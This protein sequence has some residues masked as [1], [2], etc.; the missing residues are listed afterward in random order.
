MQLARVPVH[1]PLTQAS[2]S[3]P[4]FS[5]ISTNLQFRSSALGQAQTWVLT[6]P[7]RHP[8]FQLPEEPGCLQGTAPIVGAS[9]RGRNA[10]KQ[11]RT[12]KA[13]L[14]KT[15]PPPVAQVRI[16]TMMERCFLDG[17]VFPN[18]SISC[19]RGSKKNK[20]NKIKELNCRFP[21]KRAE[22]PEDP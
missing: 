3:A 8:W 17:K 9:P 15:F 11:W 13:E 21:E 1:Q 7:P 5:K 22:T 18:K 14:K 2:L 16:T 10:G 6:K 4:I 19:N 20:K 12:G